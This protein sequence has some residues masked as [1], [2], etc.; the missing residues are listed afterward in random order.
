MVKTEKDR[1]FV[2]GELQLIGWQPGKC[3]PSN[4]LSKA[5]FSPGTLVNYSVLRIRAKCL[6]KAVNTV[7]L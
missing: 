3:Y 1:S 4:C 5:R 2:K 7:K 6:R